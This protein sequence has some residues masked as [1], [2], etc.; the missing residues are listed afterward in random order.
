MS[1]KTR[2]P[3]RPALRGGAKPARLERKADEEAN[4][5]PLN[6][7]GRVLST[8]SF[9]LRAGECICRAVSCVL[10]LCERESC[11]EHRYDRRIL[12]S[13]GGEKKLAVHLLRAH[14]SS[15]WCAIRGDARFKLPAGS[16]RSTKRR[17][18][19]SPCASLGRCRT[20]T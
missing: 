9:R 18:H 20:Q 11:R 12:F 4:R 16:R 1:Y 7:N 19:W 15:I 8:S 14:D 5:R 10:S 13:L 17:T 6:P 2:L 3:D